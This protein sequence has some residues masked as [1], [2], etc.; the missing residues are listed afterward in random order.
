MVKSILPKN[1]VDLITMLPSAGQTWL[2]LVTLLRSPTSNLHAISWACLVAVRG[3]G[4]SEVRHPGVQTFSHLISLR[5]CKVT[6][7]WF[8]CGF[9][10]KKALKHLAQLLAGISLASK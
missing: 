3:E 2:F 7:L 8:E 5:F 6:L 9:N 10:D 1:K 4:G